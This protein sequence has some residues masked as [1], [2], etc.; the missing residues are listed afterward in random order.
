VDSVLN[1]FELLDALDSLSPA[2]RNALVL[3]VKEDR[4]IA[5]AA[6]VLRVPGA[7][8][9]P[10]ATTHA[11]SSPP[12]GGER[13]GSVSCRE[14]PAEIA[15]ALLTGADLDEPAGQRIATCPG[16]AAEQASLR[17]VRSLRGL[18]R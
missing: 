18:A 15:A 3:L 10:A 2:H 5:E 8:S 6:G 17:H 4:S 13:P 16:R 1:R 14:V 9:R 7:P 11:C 12:V